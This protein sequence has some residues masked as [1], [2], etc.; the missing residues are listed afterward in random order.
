MNLTYV[1]D[2]LSVWVKVIGLLTDETREMG[3]ND[4]KGIKIYT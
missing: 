3:S 4:N 2:T 1:P